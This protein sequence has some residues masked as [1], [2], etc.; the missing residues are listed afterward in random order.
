MKEEQ[1]KKASSQNQQQTQI[2]HK[3]LPNF[4]NPQD[5]GGNK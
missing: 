5:K 3:E 4:P 2:I 1:E